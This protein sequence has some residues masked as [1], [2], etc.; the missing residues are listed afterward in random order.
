MADSF[1]D[2]DK[3]VGDALLHKARNAAK[4]RQVNGKRAKQVDAENWEAEQDP[5]LLQLLDEALDTRVWIPLQNVVLI[6]Q[7][8]CSNCNE[9]EQWCE[10]WY[11]TFKHR[12]DPFA[13]RMTKGRTEGLPLGTKEQLGPTVHI[14]SHCMN[15]QIAIE[16]AFSSTAAVE[17][18][19][20]PEASNA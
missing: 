1:D 7:Q 18:V 5:D 12:S 8:Q 16:V 11:T 17:P 20:K 19:R 14:C 6:H 4:P 13:T 9:M 2:L 3:L 10:G 15:T